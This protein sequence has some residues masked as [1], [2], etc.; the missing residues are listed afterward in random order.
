MTSPV[1]AIAFQSTV[2]SEVYIVNKKYIL[3]M[4]WIVGFLWRIIAD[5][6]M[7]EVTETEIIQRKSIQSINYT[8][9]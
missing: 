3:Y 4:K 2:K 9:K 8:F 1:T 7:N 6:N 5:A